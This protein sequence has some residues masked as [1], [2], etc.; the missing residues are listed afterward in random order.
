MKVG[1]SG[2][3]T[4]EA[5]TGSPIPSR[6]LSAKGRLNGR[7]LVREGRARLCR[8][9]AIARIPT[10]DIK[11]KGSSHIEHN[12]D[13]RPARAESGARLPHQAELAG[14]CR[15]RLARSVGPPRALAALAYRLGREPGA[16]WP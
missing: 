9:R 11:G 15:P 13:G 3:P 12:A 1:P 10:P 5:K 2:T 16:P 8:I 14:G 7:H 4:G 6:S